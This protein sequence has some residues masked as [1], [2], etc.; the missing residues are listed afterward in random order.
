MASL[1]HDEMEKYQQRIINGSSEAESGCWEWTKCIQ[2]NGYGRIRLPQNTIYAHRLSYAA[3]VGDIPHGIDVCHVCD[4][5]KCVNPAHLFLGTRKENMQDCAKKGRT[6]KGRSFCFGD[7]ASFAKLTEREVLEIV[8]RC[9][10]GEKQKDVATIFGVSKDNIS[11][12][13]HG[14]TWRHLNAVA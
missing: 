9:K 6:T 4:N 12:I 14:K 2:G 13:M 11:K 8:R 1:C 3:F 10:S 7:K 5:R